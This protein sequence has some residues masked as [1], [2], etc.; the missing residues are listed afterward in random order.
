M[1]Y[2]I[3][4]ITN[5]IV[6][7]ISVV[8]GILVFSVV[9]HY[10]NHPVA[11][12]CRFYP[13]A[14]L[15]LAAYKVSTC[16]LVVDGRVEIFPTQALS[17]LSACIGVFAMAACAFL[18]RRHYLLFANWV[19]AL[20]PPVLLFIINQ[21][22]MHF[23]YYR[24]LYSYAELTTFR[25]ETP[26]IFF[27]RLICVIVLS[28]SVLFS[29]FLVADALW[30]DYWR[31]ANRPAS[32]NNQVHKL[33]ARVTLMWIIFLLSGYVPLF[34]DSVWI[35]ILF[36]FLY[37][38]MLGISIFD[39]HLGRKDIKA[40]VVGADLAVLIGQR[41]P[42]LL[43][44]ERGGQTPWGT[45]TQGNPFFCGKAHIGNVAA[46]LGVGVD[47]ISAYVAKRGYN[48]VAW[49]SEQRLLHCAQQV[50]ETDRKI[51]EIAESCG[52]NDLPTFSRAFKRQFGVS[53]SEYRRDSPQPSL[54]GREKF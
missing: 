8:V 24:P 54:V 37:F 19:M 44:M 13:F 33:S 52:Y 17:L 14:L 2:S 1:S 47:D 9:L 50:A 11:L 46:A 39:Y 29:L 15:L 32:D 41:L 43:D 34:M 35:H 4:Y 3:F 22:M 28:M 40:Q 25:L 7:L 48:L 51:V 26:L 21:L 10:K 18:N 30:H 27:A 20:F 42:V 45:M 36:N 5:I 23:E 31:L 16:Y 38:A 6:A 53:P 12:C 49:M